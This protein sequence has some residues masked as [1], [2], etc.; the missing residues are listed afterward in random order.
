MLSRS[1][2][3]KRWIS[4]RAINSVPDKP[5]RLAH[6]IRIFFLFGGSVIFVAFVCIG[7]TILRVN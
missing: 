4:P 3:A 5:N 6:Y 7:S 2:G 1:I